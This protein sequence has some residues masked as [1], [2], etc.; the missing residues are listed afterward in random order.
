MHA[1][2]SSQLNHQ[3]CPSR[4]CTSQQFQRRGK[5]SRPGD[6]SDT[7]SEWSGRL[8]AERRPRRCAAYR[9]GRN[10]LLGADN[11]DTVGIRFHARP[12][13]NRA[14]TSPRCIGYI[15][16][17][18]QS[19]THYYHIQPPSTKL[20]LHAGFFQALLHYRRRWDRRIECRSTTLSGRTR[21]HG[22][23][24][25]QGDRGHR[26]RHQRST[27]RCPNPHRPRIGRP[28]PQLRCLSKRHSVPTL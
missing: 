10:G 27:E 5:H 15:N 16:T 2:T 25:K 7:I 6:E 1:S 22:S 14:R 26:C 19:L 18:H 17:S 12:E 8:S 13:R 21:C 20:H 3:P 24:R 28:T 23:G 11:F 4:Y 9:P